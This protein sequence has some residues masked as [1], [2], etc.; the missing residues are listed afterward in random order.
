MGELQY[1]IQLVKVARIN[2]DLSFP[3]PANWSHT[4]KNG[5][6]VNHAGGIVGG[7]GPF[8]LSSL[9][10]ESYVAKL[11]I[12]LNG[13]YEEKDVSFASAEVKTAVTVDEAF[14]AINDAG[15]VTNTVTA[16][17]TEDGYLKV[18]STKD[19]VQEFEDF[20]ILPASDSLGLAKLLDIECEWVYAK[21]AASVK[22][23]PEQET[24]ESV[25]ATGGRGIVSTIQEPDTIKDVK[26]S[27][28]DTEDNPKLEVIIAGYDYDPTT[29]RSFPPALGAAAPIFAIKSYAK[30]FGEGTSQKTGQAA[31]KM[32]AYPNCTGV[33]GGGESTAGAFGAKAF[34]AVG[35]DSNASTLPYLFKR[36]L[37][38]VQYALVEVS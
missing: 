25:S 11:K 38:N 37:T 16:S 1:S 33:I 26:I 4:D 17:K 31:M 7:A 35:T 34:S 3:S 10:G 12:G 24:G 6:T 21:N 14:A 15:F 20:E 29:G 2:K 19:G 32:V 13:T 23:D 30:L 27:F 28:E 36:R 18:V 8:D 5:A 22:F 9:V